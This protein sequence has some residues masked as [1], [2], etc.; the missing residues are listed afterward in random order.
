ML[1]WYSFTRSPL[2]HPCSLTPTS[3]WAV[4]QRQSCN[5]GGLGTGAAVAVGITPVPPMSLQE[6]SQ[7]M[8]RQTRCPSVKDLQRRLPLAD[9]LQLLLVDHLITQLDHENQNQNSLLYLSLH[10]FEFLFHFPPHGQDWRSDDPV[11]E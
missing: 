2:F 3:P 10:G 11:L 5:V 8:T 9:S 4:E 7:R 6:Q 1:A